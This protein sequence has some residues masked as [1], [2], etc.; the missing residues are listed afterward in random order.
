[1][2]AVLGVHPGPGEPVEIKAPPEIF[3]DKDKNNNK[4]SHDIMLLQ[5]PTP[6]GIAPVALPDCQYHPK[7]W[8]VIFPTYNNFKVL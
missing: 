6:S 4:R 2:N 5:L 3:T 8:V 7:T 1:M